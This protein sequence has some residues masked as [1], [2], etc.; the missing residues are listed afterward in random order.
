LETLLP[1]EAKRKLR[2]RRMTNEELFQ[3]CDSGLVLKIQNKRNLANDRKLLA[4]FK[5]FLGG[6]PPTAEL[7]RKFLAQYAN[8]KPLTHARYISTIKTFMEWCGE[9]IE[10]LPVKRL[11]A[12]PPYTTDDDIEKLFRAVK[13]KKTHKATTARDT[14]MIDL[15][16]KSGLRR[17]DLANLEEKDIFSEFLIVR[18]GKGGKDRVVPL[19]PDIAERLHEFINKKKGIKGRVFGLA[20]ASISNKIR[21]FADRA[22]LDDFHT[23]TMRH[24]FATSLVERG[25]NNRAVQ[26]LLGHSRLDTTQVYLSM[27]DRDLREAVQLLNREAH[28]DH[29]PE[30][31]A[32]HIE[33]LQ[34]LVQ[35][36]IESIPELADPNGLN[37]LELVRFKLYFLFEKLTHH[38]RWPSLE[39]RL[40]EG[41]RVFE[42]MAVELGP[43]LRPPW[44]KGL[45]AVV[46]LY[47][48]LQQ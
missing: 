41:A 34:E 47:C 45:S 43:P 31:M 15:F 20:P 23:H 18:N 35:S 38:V 12:L 17:A 5:E 21:Q 26:I 2:L 7:A 27:T 44:E 13:T 9:P 42:N 19:L 37:E 22:G 39:T 33:R 32:T 16:L 36:T 8:H 6:F 24:K 48:T 3:H 14:L 28:P 25:A 10:N 4:G 29:P 46:S 11:R 1:P 30:E 40:G